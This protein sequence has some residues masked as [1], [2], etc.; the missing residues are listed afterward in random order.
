MMFMIHLFYFAAFVG[1][2]AVLV[3]ACA[4]VR[5]LPPPKDRGTCIRFF[6]ELDRRLDEHGEADAEAARIVGFPEL[7]VDRFLASFVDKRP[8]GASYAAWIERLRALDE[9]AR[10]IEWRN[11]PAGVAAGLQPPFGLAAET[12]IDLC[13]RVL[14]EHDRLSPARR[15][16]LFEQAVVPDAYSAWQRVFGLYPLT[17]WAIVEGI[18]RLH[19]ELRQPFITDAEPWPR[20]GPWLRY[21]PPALAS[22]GAAEV[23]GILEA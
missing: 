14:A 8:A 4:G 7:R 5:T 2:V 21:A 22:L 19:R 23:A 17:R 12:A 16:R 11:L 13:G 18:G 10:R 3:Q 15:S 9:T 1:L 6:D 20:T